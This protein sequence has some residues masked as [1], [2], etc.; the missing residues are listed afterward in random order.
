MSEVWAKECREC[1]VL[2]PLGEIVQHLQG[3]SE[4]WPLDTYPTS[5]CEWCGGLIRIDP[6]KKKSSVPR[7]FCRR[8]CRQRAYER[9]HGIKVGTSRNGSKT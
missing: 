8:S 9:R 7:Q 3:C 4:P 1:H 5:E 6:A 2:A